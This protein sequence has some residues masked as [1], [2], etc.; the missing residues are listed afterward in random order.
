MAWPFR[1]TGTLVL[2]APAACAR[3][4]HV[5][6]MDL[7]CRSYAELAGRSWA[8]IQDAF[9]AFAAQGQPLLDLMVVDFPPICYLSVICQGW[10]RVL[11][12]DDEEW[13]L[14]RASTM[15]SHT[16]Y[17]TATFKEHI[18]LSYWDTMRS[19]WPVFALMHRVAER[20]YGARPAGASTAASAMRGV[21]LSEKCSVQR[22]EAILALAASL[23]P[24]RSVQRLLLWAQQLME[25]C[26]VAPSVLMMLREAG[27]VLAQLAAVEARVQAEPLS[28]LPAEFPAVHLPAPP[29]RECQGS[30]H[31][32]VDVAISADQAHMEGL[33]ALL[34]SI[35]LYTGSARVHVFVLEQELAVFAAGLSCSFKEAA[36]VEPGQWI[37]NTTICRR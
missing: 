25:A 15:E 17:T 4:V 14:L 5:S 22:A 27:P 2:L 18:P 21:E 30:R 11:V 34:K 35:S 29:V 26:D 16:L 24:G 13:R 28:A 32:V 23:A 36:A 31:A 37:L 20:F 12:F 3:D 1:R 8:A 19:G 7:T 9:R 33:V 10:A 6:D